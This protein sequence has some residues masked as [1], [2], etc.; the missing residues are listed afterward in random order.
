M[1][2]QRQYSDGTDLNSL[3]PGVSQI[4]ANDMQDPKGNCSEQFA[5]HLLHKIVSQFEYLIDMHTASFGRI[6]SLYVRA[7]MVSMI[8]FI[9]N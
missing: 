5:Y 2:N 9:D 7:D 3:F 4:K 8:V 1:L 6:N